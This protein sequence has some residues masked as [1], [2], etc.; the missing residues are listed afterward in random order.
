MCLGYVY[1]TCALPI[2]SRGCFVRLVGG[3]ED[4][5]VLVFST[6]PTGV[7][8]ITSPPGGVKRRRTRKKKGGGWV[9]AFQA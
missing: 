5:G 1:P 7:K 8:K 2:D 6:T 4:G 3:Y 9:F